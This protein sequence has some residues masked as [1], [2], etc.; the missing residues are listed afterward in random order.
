MRELLFVAFVLGM[1]EP[2]SAWERLVTSTNS[3][4][5]GEINQT[6]FVLVDSTGGEVVVPRAAITRF[7]ATPDGLKAM[8]K[9]GTEVV[10]TLRDKI[11]I[12]DGLVRRRFESADVR[13]VEFDRFIVIDA[14]KEYPS[15]PIRVELDVSALLT[16]G[17]RGLATSS[18]RAVACGNLRI[19][20]LTLTPSGDIKAGKNA[21]VTAKLIVTVPE[22]QDQLI[23][24]SAQLLQG[25]K[26]VARGRKRFEADEGENVPAS[27]L[28]T[29]P[30]QL[31]DREGPPPRL[32]LQLVS[33]DS[34]REVEKG[35]FF[36]WFT[37][38][39]G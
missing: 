14:Q 5:E 11:E 18:P 30:G 6:E 2:V 28:L 39:I 29:F 16:N 7:E 10:G 26:L 1:A 31:L 38:R 24:L 33:Q 9:D 22:G 4:I 36:W 23:D 8:I 27:F 35:G 32:L 13:L 21:T 34:N 37:F 17:K 12:G 25:D 15:C 3:V 19:A 20:L